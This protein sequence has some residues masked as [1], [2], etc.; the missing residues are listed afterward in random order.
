MA[1][2]C[3]CLSVNAYFLPLFIEPLKLYK[4]VDQGVNCVVFTESYIIA[5]MK[6]RPQLPYDNGPGRYLFTAEP[7]YPPSLG[8]AVS[9]IP[10]ASLSFFMRHNIFP[11]NGYFLD[12]HAGQFLAVTGFLVI[13]FSF[14]H[15]ED[16]DLVSF[17][18]TH[19]FAG[20]LGALNDGPADPDVI[21]FADHQNLVKNDPITFCAIYLLDGHHVSFRDPLLLSACFYHCIHGLIPLKKFERG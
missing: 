4:T 19:Y 11:L 21:V 10:G 2:N 8:I 3:L 9:S 7:L 6:H 12:S 16:D 15:L 20:Y 1:V 5:L 18:L 13:A 14:F 17:C